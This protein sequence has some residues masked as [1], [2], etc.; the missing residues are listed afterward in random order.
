MTAAAKLGVSNYGKMQTVI[1]SVGVGLTLTCG[2]ESVYKLFSAGA[3]F[4]RGADIGGNAA[5]AASRSSARPPA[6]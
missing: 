2:T 3:N 6:P 4:I 5:R 1:T